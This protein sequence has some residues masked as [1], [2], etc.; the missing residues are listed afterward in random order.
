VA[1]ARALANDPA[2]LLADEPTGSLDSA[3]GARILDLL[4]QLRRERGLTIV[5]VTHDM[6]VASRADRI[7]HMLDGRV[8]R[9][10]L[11]RERAS[12]QAG[13]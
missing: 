13:S 10:E 4:E 7:V 1:I 3:A 5:M 8:V 6:D 11:T 12:A 9:S 2:I